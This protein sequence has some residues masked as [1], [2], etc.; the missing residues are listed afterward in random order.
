MAT[1]TSTGSVVGIKGQVVEVRF[2]GNQPSI[3]DLLYLS[4]D[5]NVRLEVHSSS[6]RDS[7]YCLALGEVTKIYRGAKIVNTG[8]SVMFPVGPSMLGRVVDIFGQAQ[9]PNG[10]IR[11]K[12]KMPIHK[13]T[14]IN[15]GYSK[16]PALIETGIKVIDLFAPILKGGKMGM[17]GGAGV[18]KTMLLTEILHN[19]VARKENT[20]SVFAGIGE[21]SREGL[22]LYQALS[23][24]DALNLTSLVF[25]PMGENPSV[26]YLSGYAAATLAE[27]YRDNMTKDV[28]FFIDNIFRFAQAGNEIS[29]MTESLPSEDGYQSNLESQMAQ[30]HERLVANGKN[31]ITSIE[32]VYVPADDL[33]DH[34][35]QAIFPYLSSVVV[36]SRNIYQEGRLPAVDVLSSSSSALKAGIVGDLH[37][38]VSLK[39]KQLLRESQSLERIVSLVGEA[40]LSLE[41]QNKFRRARKLKNFMTQR[42]LGP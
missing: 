37:Y 6:S 7:F 11:T 12:N 1:K 22:E 32:A 27:Y 13:A 23:R 8:S 15:S 34:G 31:D 42:D 18:G 9:D 29:V 14:K 38:E 41:D 40:E 17:F 3:N 2:V 33:V 24:S 19:V 10:S 4:E 21:R 16:S 5:Q 26:R 39:A 35:V 28:L 30:L 20:L 25:G 36:M